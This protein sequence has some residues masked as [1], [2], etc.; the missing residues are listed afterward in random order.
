M[1]DTQI[2]KEEYSR[3]HKALLSANAIAKNLFAQVDE[4]EH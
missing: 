2:Y 1:L 3:E 4:K